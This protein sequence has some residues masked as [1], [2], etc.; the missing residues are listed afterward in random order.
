MEF[1]C[2]TCRLGETNHWLWKETGLGANEEKN[3]QLKKG[4]DYVTFGYIPTS[5]P[6]PIG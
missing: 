4:K 3:K 5:L 6:Y 2:L 1:L